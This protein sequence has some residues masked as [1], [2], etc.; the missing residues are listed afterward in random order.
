[1]NKRI[2]Y[3]DFNKLVQLLLPIVLRKNKMI[4]WLNALIFPIFKM[5]N[6]YDNTAF[7]GYRDGN[8]YKLKITPQVVYLKR[9]L[10]DKYDIVLRR[11]FI[12]DTEGKNPL[13]IYLEEEEKPAFIFKEVENKPVFLWLD[14]E[15]SLKEDD[16]IINIPMDIA[17][18]EKEL[19]MVVDNYKL[20]GKT[21]LINKF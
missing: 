17:F 14:G 6:D 5:Y 10:N 21:Y 4:A 18:D 11:I 15:T 13:Y 9:L 7:V 3:I 16:F 2:F 19:R 8:L 1:M 12:T 20:A